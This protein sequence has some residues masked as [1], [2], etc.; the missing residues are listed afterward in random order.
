MPP[1]WNDDNFRDDELEFWAQEIFGAAIDVPLV[2]RDAFL[3]AACEGSS[4]L[5]QRV[6]SLLGSAM[7]VGGDDASDQIH[8]PGD[9]VCDCLILSRIGRGGTAEVYK[10]IQKSPRRLVAVK[11]IKNIRTDERAALARDATFTSS[12]EH[13]NVVTIYHADFESDTPCVVME[14]VDGIT[15][16]EWIKREHER[17]PQQL[18]E[19][20]LKSVAEQLIAAL[21]EAHSRGLI[22]RDIKPEN[23]LLHRSGQGYRVKLVDFGL[24][25][26]V[27]SPQIRVAGT[28]GYISPEQLQGGRPDDRA[29]I[30]SVGVV[31]YEMLTGTHPFIGAT[32]AETYL[33]TIQYEPEMPSGKYDRVVRKA[34]QKAPAH[35]YQSIE[36]LSADLR[37]AEAHDA[38]SG[39]PFL[40]EFPNSVRRWLEHHVSG[41]NVAVLSCLWG[42]VSLVLSVIARAAC[43]RVLWTPAVGTSR[44]EMIYGYAVEPNAGLWYVAGVPLCVIGGFAFLHSIHVGLARTSVLSIANSQIT[45]LEHIAAV[46]RRYFYYVVPSIV[47]FA[48]CFVLIP[49]VGFRDA[50]AFGWVQADLAGTYLNARYADLRQKGVVGDLPA[51]TGLCSDCAVHATAIYN[52]SDGYR[53]PNGFWFRVFLAFALTHQ[54]GFTAFL[55][56]IAFKILFFFALLSRALL[57]HEHAGVRLT[58]DLADQDDYR[59]GLGRLD[60]VYYSILFILVLGSLGRVLQAIANL[61]K[62]TNFF[63]ERWGL[64][65]IG[66]LVVLI[67]ALL[68]FAGVILTPVIVFMLLT[69]KSVDQELARLSLQRKTA[70]QQLDKVRFS[71]DRQRI[72][73]EIGALQERRA[74][75]RNQSLLPRKRPLFWYL[76]AAN[77]V[78]LLII[79]AMLGT[80]TFANSWHDFSRFVCAACGNSST[81]P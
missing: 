70:E 4:R 12:F 75:V 58:P 43:I 80:E 44:Y 31:L 62:G 57:G 25:R 30:F 77:I 15:L 13:D 38:V 68:V 63:Q 19:A 24:A 76:I 50:N 16:R 47:L 61:Y 60:N 46:N 8:R 26:Y 35:R 36:E 79:P 72:L 21:R 48:F 7:E 49:E 22:H 3:V 52:G 54:I 40:S 9:L 11:I 27:D 67:C 53:A 2:R 14:F 64:A 66:Q 32:E 65:L 10:A 74:I 28:P 1:F 78:L 29:D 71:Q 45:P 17:M 18:R 42:C 33:K 5:K 73:G 39:N 20:A 34:L 23:V 37:A 59:L 6:I 69:I 55:L 56:Y 41:F 51:V 81:M